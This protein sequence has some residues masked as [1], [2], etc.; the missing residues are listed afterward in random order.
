MQ[1]PE[2]S[3]PERTL[4]PSPV[5]ALTRFVW[6]V[7]DPIEQVKAPQAM[8]PHYQ[9]EGRNLLVLPARISPAHLRVSFDAARHIH[10]LNGWIVTVP[11]KVPA[12]SWV[13]ELSVAARVAGAVNAIRFREGR[14]LGDLFDG[15]GFTTSLRRRGRELRS[16]SALVLGAGGVGSAIALA[17]GEAGASRVGIH[18]ID[19]ARA[20]ALTRRLDEL[21]RLA[22]R[23]ERASPQQAQ[24]FD[25]IVNASPVGMA[26][27]ARAPL[28][29]SLL[30]PRH[31]VAE[32]VMTPEITPL[33]R[34]ARQ[35][36]C[37]IHPG[38]Q[39]LQG[40]LELLLDYFR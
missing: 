2:N 14:A 40:Q 39:V 8:N 12:A 38:S 22:T 15:V 1:T 29:L 20:E 26:G 23:F 31:T 28:D 36:G 11:H 9:R 10:N 4:Q 27:D 3:A 19:A 13:D 21:A 34:A 16:S 18:D 5:D 35:L 17:L 7:G 30:L 37:E 24:D 25:L 32:V 6:I 33:L